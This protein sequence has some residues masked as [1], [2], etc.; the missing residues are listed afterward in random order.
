[1]T[2]TLSDGLSQEREVEGY[3]FP[4][5][6]I[7]GGMVLVP[8]QDFAVANAKVPALALDNL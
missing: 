8:E 4:Y 6:H 7:A 3:Y 2:V 1:M 5:S